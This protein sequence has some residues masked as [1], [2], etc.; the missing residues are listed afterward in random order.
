[1]GKA[2]TV[3]TAASGTTGQYGITVA[4]DLGSGH[5][6]TATLTLNAVSPVILAYTWQERILNWRLDGSN[7]WGDPSMPDCA[8]LH[9]PPMPL[10]NGEGLCI[11]QFHIE[12]AAGTQIATIQRSGTLTPDASGGF[13]LNEDA[14]QG[15]N[16]FSVSYVYGTGTITTGTQ[17]QLT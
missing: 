5:V 17:L 16:Q 8:R 9:E 12:P 1:N 15:L 2:T 10:T 6:S 7:N 4:L 13:R 3:L 11:I 14:S